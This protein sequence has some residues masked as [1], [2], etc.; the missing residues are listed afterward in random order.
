MGF[1]T[2]F[3]IFTCLFIAYFTQLQAL[4]HP[5]VLQSK[6]QTDTLFIQQASTATL[7][8]DPNT[9]NQYLLTLRGL[10]PRIVYVSNESK[11]IA[12]VIELNDFLENWRE[13]QVLFKDDGPS[14]IMSYL[15]FKP[16]IQSG[17]VTDVLQLTK[18]IYDRSTNSITFTA[19]PLH[20]N[21]VR[22]GRFK[23]IVV[24]YDGLS[25]STKG[26]KSHYKVMQGPE[27]NIYPKGSL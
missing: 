25:A 5:L 23:N 3:K 2:T 8:Q 13:N 24:V 15:S 17:V 7:K 1:K 4:D 12:G 18:P 22:T 27:T 26:L 14:A 16:S 19:K 20:K 9:P 10:Y 21:R 6:F 11:H